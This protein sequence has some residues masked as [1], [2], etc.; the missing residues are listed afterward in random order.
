MSVPPEITSLQNPLI[1]KTRQLLSDRKLRRQKRLLPLEGLR[2][3][4]TAA[5]AGSVFQTILV[6]PAALEVKAIAQLIATLKT[7][8]VATYCV[9]EQVFRHLSETE[10]PQGILAIVSDPQPSFSD[11]RESETGQLTQVLILDRLQDP[12]NVGTILRTAHGA[13]VDAVLVTSGSCDVTNPKCLRA[14]MGS[15]FHQRVVSNIPINEVQGWLKEQSILATFTT[16][17]CNDATTHDQ[18]DLAAPHALILGNEANGIGAE[19]SDFPTK[20]LTIPLAKGA[21]SLNVASAAAVLL[22][23]AQRQR[24]ARTGA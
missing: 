9:S 20:P 18:A 15:Y 5:A 13:G 8:Q 17:L 3:C 24:R 4:E 2:L 21:E 12:G 19:W 11:F 22:F 16:V 10:S 1:K 6:T 23:E 7:Q 14:S